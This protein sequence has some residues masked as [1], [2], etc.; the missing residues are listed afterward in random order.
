MCLAFLV[1]VAEELRQAKKDKDAAQIAA[2]QELARQ[3]LIMGF[4]DLGTVVFFLLTG[5]VATLEEYAVAEV[6]IVV[7]GATALVCLFAGFACFGLRILWQ[8]RTRKRVFA[9]SQPNGLDVILRDLQQRVEEIQKGIG[10]EQDEAEQERRDDATERGEAAIDREEGR[11]HRG[12][13]K[14]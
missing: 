10:E 3:H 13:N 14:E 5:L 12:P 6:V 2:D 7:L 11:K 8:R 9:A 4:L 1:L